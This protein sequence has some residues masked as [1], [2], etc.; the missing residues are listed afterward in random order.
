MRVIDVDPIIKNLKD[1]YEGF[2]KEYDKYSVFDS[3]TNVAVY[4]SLMEEVD[5]I[6]FMLEN[7]PTVDAIPVEWI[8]EIIQLAETT[9][10][11]NWYAM[12]L[13]ILL[14]EWSER[15]EE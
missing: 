4:G 11:A 10:G 12:N 15:K 5:F 2:S 6:T 8:E 9:Y 7:A 3:P 13:R 1:E 14:N